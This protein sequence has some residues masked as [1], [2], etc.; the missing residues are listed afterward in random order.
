V[1]C[2]TGPTGTIIGAGAR[3]AVGLTL[4]RAYR[5]VGTRKVSLNEDVKLVITGVTC[6]A[7]PS[8]FAHALSTQTEPVPAASIAGHC[9]DRV[10]LLEVVRLVCV[11]ARIRTDCEAHVKSTTSH[12][13]VG[14][15][16]Y[17]DNSRGR[18]NLCCLIS[19]N[20]NRTGI[21]LT[22]GMYS[23]VDCDPVYSP[24]LVA[25]VKSVPSYT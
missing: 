3:A 19:P 14:Y 2:R 12:T 5:F 24:R 21:Y 11:L 17:H 8:I 1:I 10:S 4:G 25:V 6:T 16:Q 18:Y 23:T 7:F 15:K 22:L 13:V 9:C 20:V